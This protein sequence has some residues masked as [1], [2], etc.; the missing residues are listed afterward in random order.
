M[1]DFER[2]TFRDIPLKANTS[3]E[4]VGR[5]ASFWGPANLFQG[6][7]IHSSLVKVQPIRMQSCQMK[8]Y[9]SRLGLPPTQ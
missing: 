7:C 2:P 8:V 6:G 4:H 3:P 5:L 9:M 1:M